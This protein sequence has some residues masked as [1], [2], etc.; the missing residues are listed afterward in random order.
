MMLQKVP[1]GKIELTATTKGFMKF[2]ERDE[3]NGDA[4]NWWVPDTECLSGIL[5]VAGFNYFSRL[6][7]YVPGRVLLIATKNEES[8]L[9]RQK[10]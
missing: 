4:S 2:Y 3:L 9:D 8:L 5:R 6:V 10:L 1:I 7:Y